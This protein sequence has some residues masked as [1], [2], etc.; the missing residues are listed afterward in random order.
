[1]DP[2]LPAFTIFHFGYINFVYLDLR[3]FQGQKRWMQHQRVRMAMVVVVETTIRRFHDL[4]HFTE[5]TK[6]CFE[7]NTNESYSFDGKF[8]FCV[9]FVSGS[10]FSRVCVSVVGAKREKASNMI[11]TNRLF[12]LPIFQ[13]GIL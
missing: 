12:C 1:M 5:I 9:L 3:F 4:T 13:Y 6:Y 7:S 8:I 11:K 2:G 10:S